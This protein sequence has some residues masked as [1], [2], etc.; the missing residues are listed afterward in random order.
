MTAAFIMTKLKCSAYQLER[1]RRR[2]QGGSGAHSIKG[3]SREVHTAW[4]WVKCKRA[5]AASGAGG[6]TTSACTSA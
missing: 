4:T 6:F 1:K 2:I 5:S 3:G